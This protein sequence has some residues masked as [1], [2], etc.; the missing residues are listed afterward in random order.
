MVEKQKC[1]LVLPEEL[2]VFS[3]EEVRESLLKKTNN[4]SKVEL[5]FQEVEVIDGAGLQLLISLKKCELKDGLQ[6]SLINVSK[7]VE[8][9]LNSTGIGNLLGVN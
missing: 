1:R 2:T 6:L 8:K 3:I 4:S 5:D 9:L 7:S